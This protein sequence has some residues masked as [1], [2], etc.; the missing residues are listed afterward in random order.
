M[1]KK[2]PVLLRSLNDLESAAEPP[3]MFL[4]TVLCLRGVEQ[5]A[6]PIDH[7]FKTC[8]LGDAYV[9]CQIGMRAIRRHSVH[10]FIVN[11]VDLSLSGQAIRQTPGQMSQ[12]VY[13]LNPF[14]RR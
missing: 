2:S 14:L 12:N 7:A 1:D 9:P 5:R 8:S 13:T 10:T 4:P 6:Q 11:N 3:A